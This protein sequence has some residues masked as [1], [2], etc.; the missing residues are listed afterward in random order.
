MQVR[1]DTVLSYEQFKAI[2]EF[3]RASGLYSND[4]SVFR[5]GWAWFMPWL[6]CPETWR[7]RYRGHSMIKTDR[8][9]SGGFLSTHYWRDHAAFR[10]PITVV[11]PDGG[12]WCIDQKSNNGDG[13]TVTGELPNITCS[14]SI[15]MGKNPEGQHYHGFLQ[16]G[17]FT[18]DLD[19]QFK[20]PPPLCPDDVWEKVQQIIKNTP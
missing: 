3:C 20:G 11:C 15:V 1:I 7:D 5:P 19:G 18:P 2:N 14:P 10:P 12:Q 17:A 16:N 8:I 9:E 6:Y 13:W 4:R